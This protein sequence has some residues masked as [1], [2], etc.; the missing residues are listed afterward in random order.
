[1]EKFKIG[2]LVKTVQHGYGKIIGWV[3][4]G[5]TYPIAVQFPGKGFVTF[6]EEG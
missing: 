5:S 1:M 2:D 6:T 4:N 3:V